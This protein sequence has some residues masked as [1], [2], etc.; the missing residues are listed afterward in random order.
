MN[1]TAII[2][3]PLEDTIVVEEFQGPHGS[4]AAE[5]HFKDYLENSENILLA[6]IP[7][8]HASGA[9][10]VQTYYVPEKLLT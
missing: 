1:W 6:I 4:S 9:H 8:C 2:S 7:G 10:V 5:K 3:K